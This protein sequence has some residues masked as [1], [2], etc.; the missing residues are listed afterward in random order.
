MFG[1]KKKLFG[2]GRSIKKLENRDLM[3]AI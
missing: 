2:A 3:Q 1:L